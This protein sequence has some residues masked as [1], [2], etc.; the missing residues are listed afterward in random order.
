PVFAGLHD[1]FYAV[2]SRDW[3]IIEPRINILYRGAK[4]LCIEKERPHVP[5]ERAIMAMRLNDYF[6]GTQFH[7][8]ADATGIKRHLLTE[9][10]KKMVVENYGLVKWQS[11]MDHLKDP[12]KISW[13]H[14]H[15]LPNFLT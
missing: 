9:E 7:P 14:S 5:L 13:T 3:Q 1:P 2:D 6:F 10:K 15:I 11:M 8:E 12:D 4:V